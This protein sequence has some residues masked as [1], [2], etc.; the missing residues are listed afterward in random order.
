MVKGVPV[1]DFRG[2]ETL[3][4]HRALLLAAEAIGWL[5]MTGKAHPDFLRRHGGLAPRYDYQK[6]HERENPQFPW[7]NLFQWVPGSFGLVSWPKSTYFIEKHTGR[8][9]GLLGLFQ[10]AHGIVSGIEKN[11]PEKASQY[12]RQDATHM[13]LCSAFGYPTRNLL[14]DPP[15]T[16]SEQGWSRLLREIARILSELRELGSKKVADPDLWWAWRQAAIGP[17]SGLR[18]TFTSTLA[19]TRLPNN[20][21]TLWDQSYVAAALFK[22][23][24]AGAVLE[25]STFP[26]SDGA[27]KQNTRWRLLTIGIGANHYEARAVRIGDWTGARLAID[28]IFEKVRRL[29]EVDLAVGAV[30]YADSATQVFSFPSERSAQSG[31]L[32]VAAWKEFLQAEIDTYAQ[33]AGLETPPYCEISLPSRSLV[34]M[35]R[36]VRD[37]DDVL[38]VPLHRAW[39]IPAEPNSARQKGHVCPVCLVRRSLDTSDKQR[40]CEPCRKRRTHRLDAWIEGKLGRDTIW[41]D[42]VADSNDRVALITMDLDIEPWLDAGRLDAL[43]TQSVSEWR[44]HNPFVGGCANPID[45]YR[46]FEGLV[47][48]VK[49]KLAANFDKSDPVLTSLQEGYQ[50]ESDWKPFYEKIVEDRADAP[51]WDKVRDDPELCARWLVHQLF[52]KLASP[53]RV[54]RFWR[55][56]EEFFSDRL[57]E[58]REIASAD[59]NRRRVRRLVLKPDAATKS[60]GWED[61]ELY[62]GQ[63]RDAPFVLLY[64]KEIDGFLTACNLARLL[65][66]DESADA[67]KNVDINVRSDEDRDLLLRVEK[68]EDAAGSLGVYHPVIPLEISPLR[69]RLLVPLKAASKCV[70][71]A[72]ETWNDQFARV[73]DRLP[74]RIGIIAFP[75]MLPFQ[76]VIETAR[77]VEDQLRAVGSE[78]LRVANVDVRDGVAA[79]RF[80][81][82]DGGQEVRTVP[83]LLRD[84][85]LDAFYV[86]SAVEDSKARSASDFQHPGGQVYRHPMDLR[87]GDRVRV[88]PARVATIFLDSTGKRFEEVRVRPVSDWLQMRAVWHLVE[89]TVPS[90]TAVRGAWGELCARRET[91]RD[92]NGGSSASAEEAWCDL[93]RAILSK[94]WEVSG[95]ALDALVEAAR[96][97]ILALSLEWHLSALKER[98][99]ETTNV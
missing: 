71:R 59:A 87:P 62:N 90:L 38:A 26:W 79:F 22:S 6:W 69:F 67:F 84:G 20:D 61:R 85:R 97:G 98:F 12:L 91:W 29:I 34:P 53:G 46:P 32:S 45:P 93:V 44:R 60:K 82:A 47:G 94:R 17:S 56:A 19:E 68:I 2:E 81:R 70:E 7:D 96:S 74:L 75:R 77:S 39:S 83:F 55:Q 1:G 13:W 23:A 92:P 11:L 66:A 37:A 35:T 73:R 14:V 16:L 43:R 33:E 4:Q 5:H 9:S 86:Y 50:H 51:S 57:A 49:T 72:I 10:A 40:P 88:H 24:V 65:A 76:A 25:G 41:I 52:R 31:P 48:Y 63:W 8:N 21:V 15:E 42:E 18:T 78:T 58:F 28:E 99:T 80:T 3:R 95:A 64:R 30:L 89:R 36:E 27:I 54:Y